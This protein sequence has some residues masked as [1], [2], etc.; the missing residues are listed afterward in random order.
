MLE[1]RRDGIRKWQLVHHIPRPGMVLDRRYISEW[2]KW[3]DGS[4]MRLVYLPEG[5][6]CPAIDEE[7][8]GQTLWPYPPRPG[9]AG[10]IQDSGRQELCADERNFEL[11]PEAGEDQRHDDKNDDRR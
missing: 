1:M 2:Q 4:L 5:A 9:S 10:R 8:D 6:G 7:P 11:G 3:D